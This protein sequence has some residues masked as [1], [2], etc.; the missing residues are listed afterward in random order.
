MA[1][2]F[3]TGTIDSVVVDWSAK[4]VVLVLSAV[5]T[6]ALIVVYRL[7]VEHLAAFTARVTCDIVIVLPANPPMVRDVFETAV[8]P[9]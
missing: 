6:S 7:H 4:T 2:S 5:P 8:Q 3:D 1:L 9:D